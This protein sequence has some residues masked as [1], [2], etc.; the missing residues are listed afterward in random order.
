MLYPLSY[1]RAG[2]E[3]S[4]GIVAGRA[5]HTRPKRT[6]ANEMAQFSGM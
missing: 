4:A 3:C 2:V 1:S 5:G 6:Q